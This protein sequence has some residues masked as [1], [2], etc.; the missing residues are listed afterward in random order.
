MKIVGFEANNG[1]RLG[2]VDG[3][4]VV[5]LQ[6]VDANV[7]TDLAEVLRRSNG[8]LSSIGALAKKAPASAHRPLD[9]LKYALPQLPR[10]CEGRPAARQHPEISVN[11]LSRADFDGAS[12]T[13]DHA[14]EGIDP[15]RLRSRDGC[16]HRQAYQASVDG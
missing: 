5:D 11:F 4:N 15:A 12:W 6:A 2:V 13:A 7:P 10:P 16:D 9:G 3:D 1:V 14:A 8:D